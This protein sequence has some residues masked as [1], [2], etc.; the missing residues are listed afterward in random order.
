MRKSAMYVAIGALAVGL[1][2]P[3]LQGQAA[4]SDHDLVRVTVTVRRHG[5]NP[6]STLARQD[7]LVYQD[8]ERRPVVDWVAATGAHASLD[9]AILIDDSVSQELGNQLSDLRGFIGAL[10]PTTKVAIVYS[11]Q[12][13]AN[14][15][16]E[17]TSEHEKAAQALRLPL[18]RGNE[19]ASIYLAVND[20]IKHWPADDAR[21]AIL[22]VSDGIDLY[23][24]V[25]DSQPT[26]NPDLQQAIDD[27][28]QKGVTVYTLFASGAGLFTHNFFLI[29]NG[30]SCLGRLAYETGGESYFQGFET[31][32][33]FQPFLS[34]LA[35][36]LGEQY[37]LTFRA[38]PLAK[39][40][41]V[42]LRVTTEQPGVE[43]LAPDHVYVPAKS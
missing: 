12:G 35:Q 18:G 38:Q 17:F 6:P 11:T 3:A 40:G 25:V 41:L 43:L 30:Q 23:R 13:N 42:P 28:H 27:A 26:L 24:G 16:Q 14:F 33:A 8:K 32:V 20:L 15:L 29:S 31:P 10:P 34:K 37:L 39:A 19:G 21:K 22:L 2:A 1:A 7:V 9:L 5:P 4:P 36:T